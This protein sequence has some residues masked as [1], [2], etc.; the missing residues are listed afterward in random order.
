MSD[1]A[2]VERVARAIAKARDYREYDEVNGQPA[3]RLF[4][5]SARSAIEAMMIE[6][7]KFGVEG[8]D[9]V[10][11]ALDLSDM[12]GKLKA[13]LDKPLP[14]D[15]QSVHDEVFD[16]WSDVIEGIYGSYSSESDDLMIGA[17]KAV[18]DKTT[19]D[20]IRD[21]GFAGEFALYVLAGHRMTEYGTSPRGAWADFAIEDLWQPL[22]DKWEAYAKIVWSS[23]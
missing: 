21:Q 23:N 15:G 6:D 18:R 22:I 17:L 8:I 4:E 1:S 2:M 13:A 5:A 11:V 14:E 19:F 7:V 12:R 20:F 10:I 9:H 16:P 3:W